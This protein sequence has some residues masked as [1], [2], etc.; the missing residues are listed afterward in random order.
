M[1][2][3]T[4]TIWRELPQADVVHVRCPANI[5][6]IAIVLLAV[7]RYP[8]RRWVKYAG[9]W[10]SY[11]VEAWSYRFQRWWLSSG[12]HRG[13]VTVN[14]HWPGQPAHVYSFL[15]PCFTEAELAA[16]Q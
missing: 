6:L 15:N 14:G 7:V 3:Y 16:A 10:Q 13:V 11:P 2:H 5:S 4:R 9:N 8:R 1:P 12:L